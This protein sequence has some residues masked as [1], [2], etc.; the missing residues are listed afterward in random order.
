M[1]L[2]ELVVFNGFVMAV[3]DRT[4]VIYKI[5]KT[6]A[7]P[8]VIL[9]DGPGDVSKGNYILCLYIILSYQIYYAGV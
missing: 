5:L 3:D 6:E 9:S 8:W 4:G 2:S 7:V 1:E